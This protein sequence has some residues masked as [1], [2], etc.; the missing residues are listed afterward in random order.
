MRTS[1]NNWSSAGPQGSAYTPLIDGIAW[2]VPPGTSAYTRPVQLVE[3]L[4]QLGV[5]APETQF[6]HA[7]KAP[8]ADSLHRR[9]RWSFLPTRPSGSDAWAVLSPV[10][11]GSR[12]VVWT[13]FYDDWSIAPDINPVY[14]QIARVTYQSV[15]RGHRNSAIMTVNT[16][17]MASRLRLPPASVVPNG[18]D[19][20]L[21]NVAR[22]GD[23]SRR[24]IL[25]GRF[26]EG[27]TDWALMDRIVRFGGFDEVVIGAPGDSIRMS[28]LIASWR[29]TGSVPSVLVYPWLDST[30]LGALI[31]ENT[32]CLIPHVVDDYTR[33]QDLMKCYQ[34][35]ALGV[36]VIIPPELWPERLVVPNTLPIERAAAVGSSR[37]LTDQERADVVRKHSWRARAEQIASTIHQGGREAS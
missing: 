22:S 8:S 11:F 19:P 20:A 35:A 30:A 23:A 12:K 27:R 4:E 7:G 2:S 29:T 25:L 14:R 3:Q 31:G 17:Y 18:V 15:S 6:V 16:S 36:P 28:Q 37:L 5:I 32:A 1:V 13:D 24:V 9:A 26:M 33:S 21:A 34:M 10:F